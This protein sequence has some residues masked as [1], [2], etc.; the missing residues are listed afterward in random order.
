M[1]TPE[2]NYVY[3]IQGHPV[4]KPSKR[5]GASKISPKDYRPKQI[6]SKFTKVNLGDK[7]RYRGGLLT[8]AGFM[9]MTTNNG[10][11]TNP[12]YRG[13]WVLKSFYG[14]PLETPEDLEI[15]ALSPPTKTKTIKETIDAHRDDASCNICHKK[16][17]PLGIALE[18]FDVMGRWRDQYTDVNNY[19][20]NKNK[21]QRFPV[22]TRTAHMD[23]RAFEGP[24]GLKKILM[25]D[26]ERFSR[27]FIENILSYAMARQL[28]FSDR[29]NIN[30]LYEQSA[31]NDF[32][33]RDILLAIISAESFTKR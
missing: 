29:K 18:N 31:K 12:F 23:G 26:K 27:A 8:Q 6:T 16:M 17:D 33:L 4:A 13:A 7:D 5:P 1:I 9:L 19:T 15:S 3:R 32:R 21:G 24:Q 11:Y 2:L 10:E 20:S 22:D 28:T 25:E 14:D 30:Q